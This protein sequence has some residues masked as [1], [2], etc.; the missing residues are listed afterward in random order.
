MF[1]KY[2]VDD[3]AANIKK[4]FKNI[5]GEEDKSPGGDEQDPN[6]CSDELKNIHIVNAFKDKKGKLACG[7]PNVFAALR[8]NEEDSPKMI[9][10]PAAFKHGGINKQYDIGFTTPGPGPTNCGTIGDR[11]SFR[12]ET[13]GAIILHEYT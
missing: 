2:F 3:S 9:I 6:P 13:L 1:D 5:I 11:T 12:M 4:V 10:C 8:D 7:K